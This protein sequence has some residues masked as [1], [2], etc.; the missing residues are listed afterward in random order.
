MQLQVEMR[1]RTNLW[2]GLI[3]QVTYTLLSVAFVGTFLQDGAAVN[4]WGFWDI[5]FLFGLGD[6]T[7][8]LSAIFVFR[9]FLVFDSQY[10]IEG[11]LDQIL[12]QP[13]HPL[14]NL[15]FRNLNVNDGIIVLKGLAIVWLASW[16]LPLS[17]SPPRF[18]LF[19][20]LAL[21]GALVYAGVYVLFLSLG[22]WLPRRTSFAGPLLSLN[23]LTQYPLTI[24][25]EG[26]QVFLSFIV[27]LG[28]ASFYPAQAFLHLDPGLQGF[29]VPLLYIP[30]AAILVAA[31]AW[32]V[33]SLGL[34]RYQSS[35]T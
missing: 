29:L 6:I 25:P 3:S 17:W 11:G 21:S 5:I 22:F 28:F 9:A 33:F 1:Y 34:G 23:Y 31:I 20:M 30:L 10:V 14:V 24:Y 19:G 8:G 32:G 13:I 35:G 15:I 4:G 26:L 12:T 2:V 16:S 18:L 7:F 27:P